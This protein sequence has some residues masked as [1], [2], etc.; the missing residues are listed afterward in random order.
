MPKNLEVK[1]RPIPKSIYVLEGDYRGHH[2]ENETFALVKAYQPYPH[3]DGGFVTVKV[4]TERFPKVPDNGI[5]RLSVTD[6]NQLRDK[7][8]EVKAMESDE[9][10]IERMRKRFEI[11]ERMTKATK[12]GDVRAMIVSGP[13]GVGKSY[14]V[15]T[16]LEKYEVVN[17]LADTKPKSEV[18]KGAMSA[19]GLYCK[20]HE[21]KEKD[22]IL[23]FDDCDSVLLD[24]L[25]LNILKAALDSKKVRRICW[26]TDSHMLRREGVPGAFEFKGSVIFITNIKFDNVRSKKLRDHLQALESRCHYIDLT[27]DTIREKLLRINQIVRDGMLKPYDLPQGTE[28]KVVDWVWDH[29]RRLREIS[30]R[31]VLKIADLAKAFPDIWESM[32]EQT[33]L[34]PH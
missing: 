14:G 29:K 23:V 11:L 33:V 16:V 20:L 1:S 22:N 12:K 8:P 34:K 5:I 15:E 18:V 10:T 17:T 4:A 9:E 24:D 31:T 7:T 21:L 32:A 27:I 3:K 2:V 28:K 30:L 25:S 13:P 19:I 6:E 26:N